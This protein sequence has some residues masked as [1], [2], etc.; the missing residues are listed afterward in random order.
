MLYTFG[1]P[2]VGNYDYPLALGTP[3][4]ALGGWPYHH[5]KEFFYSEENMVESS[6][7]KLCEGLPHN[8]DLGCSNNPLVWSTEMLTARV[9]RVD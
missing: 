2:R 6:P 4:I 8:K 1:Q 9:A 5:G 7:Y 3:C